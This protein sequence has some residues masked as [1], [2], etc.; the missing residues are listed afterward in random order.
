MPGQEDPRRA[1]RMMAVISSCDVTELVSVKQGTYATSK[2]KIHIQL[3]QP[4]AFASCI[5]HRLD[6]TKS[7]QTSKASQ[8]PSHTKPEQREKRFEA[9][10][11]NLS[12]SDSWPVLAALPAMPNV[13]K[14]L[15][16]ERDRGM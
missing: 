16:R 15:M 6:S 4:C 8:N 11:S 3:I 5:P 12:S 13:K 2:P 10:F 7:V 14:E 9:V 1:R